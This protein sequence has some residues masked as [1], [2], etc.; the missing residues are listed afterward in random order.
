MDPT[1]SLQLTAE[2]LYCAAGDFH[3]DP[4]R[5]VDRAVVTH[6]HADHACWGCRA[7]P[8]LARGG[9]R[10]PR[11]G[12]GARRRSR[13]SPTASGVTSGGSASRSI[14]PGTS[15]AR[16]RS[17]SSTRGEVWVVSG[18]YKIEPDPTCTPFEPVRCHTFVTESTFGL[19]I[20]RWPAQAEVFA[21]INAW[22]RANQRGGQGEPALRLRPRQGAAAAGGPRP[23]HRPDLHARRGREAQP[24]LPRGRR[25]AAPRRPM[26]APQPKG[27][28]WS[29]AMIVAPPRRTG[30]PGPRVRPAR[31]AGSPRAGCRSAGPGAAAPSIAASSSPTTSTGRACSAPSRRPGPRRV[32]VTHGYTAASS[33]GSASTASTPGAIATRFEGETRRGRRRGRGA[34]PRSDRHEERFAELYTALDETTRTSE[35][36]EALTPLLRARAG[37]PTRRGRSTS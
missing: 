15:S 22:W 21:E 8:D 32:W 17:G 3:V 12:W 1:S 7:L 6:A 19:P 33:A 2:G 5:P 37:R 30:P 31:P 18:D 4:W 29:R 27:V 16:R 23:E 34:G 10:A 24:R 14:R 28:D 20:Y 35:K 13:R 9:A 25:R 11:R 36:V 26:P